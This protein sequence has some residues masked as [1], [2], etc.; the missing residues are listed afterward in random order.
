LILYKH[1]TQE[2]VMAR[3]IILLLVLCT[4]SFAL[5]QNAH[6]PDCCCKADYIA[7]LQKQLG[8]L[9]PVSVLSG[10][11]G[12]EALGDTDVIHHDLDIEIDPSA[13]WIGG[14]N[15]MT[16]ESLIDNLADFRFRLSNTFT[17]TSVTVNGVAISWTRIDSSTVEAALDRLYDTGEQ[18]DLLVAYDGKPSGQGFGS[19]EFTSQGGH[20]LV[21]TLS[22]PWYAYTWWP[23]KET[24][25]DKTTADLRFTVPDSL[26]VASNGVLQSTTPVSGNRLTFHWKTDYPTVDYLYFFA[27]TNYNYYE[28]FFSYTGGTMPVVMYIF[29]SDDTANNRNEWWKMID[30]LGVYGD[31]YGLYPFIDEKY[32]MAQFSWGGGM[33]HQTLTTQGGFWEYITAHEASHQWWGDMITCGTWHDIWLN[34]GFATYSEALWFEFE[35]GT[36]DPSQLHYWMDVR[37]PGSVNGSVYCYDISDLWRIFSGDFTYTKAAWVLHQLRHVVGDEDFFDILAAYRA[38]YEYKSAVTDDFKAVAEG[39]HGSDLTWFF[40]EWIY[41]IGA[42]AYRYAWTQ[43]DVNGEKFVELYVRQTQSASY[44]T[45][46]MPIDI[47]TWSGGSD[48]THVVWNDAPTEHLLIPVD[49][50]VSSLEFD[51]D[52]WILRTSLSTTSF[53]GGPP[54]IISTSPAPGERVVFGTG[55]GT[56]EVVFHKDV[57]ADASDLT[58]TGYFSGERSFD[59]L[60]SSAA[61]TATLTPVGSFP[62]DFYTLT[63]SD[64]IVDNSMGLALD[65]EVARPFDPEALPSGDGLAGGAATV[66]FTVLPPLWQGSI[67]ASLGGTA[68]SITVSR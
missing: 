17:I 55:A 24:L 58:L 40:D 35:S 67:N 48:T 20:P 33:E 53:V 68:N 15:T 64:S 18:F 45:F 34:E 5:G 51:R 6:G 66:H 65:G 14:H 10:R 31:L 25:D 41:D 42:P 32:G 60:Y 44:P 38:A 36:S 27:A 12:P 3:Y 57:N 56:I 49:S 2:I 28:S 61:Q 52:E 23:V 13:K 21:F 46:T 1:A 8:H 26:K 62:A 37:R 43:H 11:T 29:P 63:I 50:S 19:I 30:I 39:V 59:F 54:K 22:S 16:V 4:G 47:T 7:R 9:P